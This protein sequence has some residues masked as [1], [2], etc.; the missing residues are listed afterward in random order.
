[1][2]QTSVHVMENDMSSQSTEYALHASASTAT[3]NKQRFEFLR[4]IQPLQSSVLPES[5]MCNCRNVLYKATKLDIKM[6]QSQQ[7]KDAQFQRFKA[8][9]TYHTLLKVLIWLHRQLNNT[10][11]P[12]G[13]G[14]RQA[15]FRKVVRKVHLLAAEKS[16]FV[17]GNLICKQVLS[18]YVTKLNIILHIPMI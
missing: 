2:Y 5:H 7:E 18:I 12:S 16:N 1:M 6:N 3:L 4:Y 10:S 13:Q 15:E 8:I 9:V 14:S 17:S 11:I